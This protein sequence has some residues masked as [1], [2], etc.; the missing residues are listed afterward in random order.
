MLDLERQIDRFG[1]WLKYATGSSGD[2]EFV[3]AF[4]LSLIHI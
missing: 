2:S 4:V 3:D 1:E